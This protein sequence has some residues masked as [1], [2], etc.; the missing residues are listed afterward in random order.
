MITIRKAGPDDAAAVQSLLTELGYPSPVEEVATRL[1]TMAASPAD[2]VL[3]AHDGPLALG[4]VALHWAPMLT[5]PRPLARITAMVVH[6]GARGLGVGRRLVEAG[7]ELAREHGCG[8]LELTT[9]LQRADAH[10]FYEAMGFTRSSL[11]YVRA[12]TT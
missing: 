10:A 11:R 4:L 12:L 2:A 9:S 3:F 5:M 7:A 8:T 6:E 1:A